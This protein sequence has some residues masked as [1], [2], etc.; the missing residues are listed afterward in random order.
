M[1]GANI[2]EVPASLGAFNADDLNL[3]ALGEN[4]PAAQRIFNE[5][6]FP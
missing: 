3:S 2:G 6:G 4:Q 5:I 1:A